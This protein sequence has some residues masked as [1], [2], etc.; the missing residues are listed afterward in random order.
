[1]GDSQGG[2]VVRISRTRRAKDGQQ[3]QEQQ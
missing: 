1:L 2:K 3:E